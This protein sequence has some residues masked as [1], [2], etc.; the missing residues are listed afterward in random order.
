M[1]ILHFERWDRR[2]HC[3]VTGRPVFT[4][5]GEV[6]APTVRGVWVHEVPE[7]PMELAPELQTA[8]DAYLAGLDPEEL[9]ID[10]DQ[11][12]GSVE[13]DGWAAFCITSRGMACG[14]VSETVWVVLDLAMDIDEVDEA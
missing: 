8:W 12:L 6:Q 14:P 9:D 10:V 7:E 3:P 5:L 11:F 4:E 1:Q 13:H 2:F